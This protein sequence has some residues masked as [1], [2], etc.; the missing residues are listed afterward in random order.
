MTLTL[1]WRKVALGKCVGASP[2]SNHW[3]G[4]HQLLYKIHFSSHITTQSKNGSSLLHG[5]KEDDTLKHFFFFFGFAVS[6][7]GP[8][9]LSVFT[10][11]V[12]FKCWVTIGWS[13][14]ISSAPSHVIV[15]GS[16]SGILSTGHCHLL[17]TSNY[18]PQL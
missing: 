4:H 13:V 7:W 3:A 8:H 1:F 10:F 14:L 18:A 11:P 9:L 17:I 5:I 15:R 2:Q 6:S 12:C 16:S